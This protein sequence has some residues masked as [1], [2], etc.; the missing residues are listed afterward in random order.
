MRFIVQLQA[1]SLLGRRRIDLDDN[2]FFQNDQGVVVSITHN[3]LGQA[4]AVAVQWATQDLQT[5]MLTEL[6]QI[7]A[8]AGSAVLYWRVRQ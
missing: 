4:W 7:Q 2:V 6:Y 3:A 1:R 8:P 5:L